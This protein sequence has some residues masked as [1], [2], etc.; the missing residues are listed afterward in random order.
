MESVIETSPLKL[1]VLA[2]MG[3]KY[4]YDEN[5]VILK[6]L[7]KQGCGQRPEWGGL[8]NEVYSAAIAA[9]S[10]GSQ[11]LAQVIALRCSATICRT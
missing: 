6:R 2:P 3:S 10:G 5:R 7:E 9:S 1:P 4:G 11:V 8:L